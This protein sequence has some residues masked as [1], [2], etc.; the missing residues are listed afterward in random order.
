MELKPHLSISLSDDDLSTMVILF[1]CYSPLRG[2]VDTWTEV[3]KFVVCIGAKIAI[4]PA[5]HED[6]TTPYD[7]TRRPRTQT[8]SKPAVCDTHR[9]QNPEKKKRREGFACT[10][11][12]KPND[13]KASNVKDTRSVYIDLPTQLTYKYQAPRTNQLITIHQVSSR[14]LKPSFVGENEPEH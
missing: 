6:Q 7:R 3:V 13:A 12:L 8:W 10:K 1:H 5:M 14:V 9:E 11:N 2:C 4:M